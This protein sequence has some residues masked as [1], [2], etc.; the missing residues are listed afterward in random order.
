MLTLTDPLR[1][2]PGDFVLGKSVGM[3]SGGVISADRGRRPTTTTRDVGQLRNWLD[4][5]CDYLS[6]PSAARPGDV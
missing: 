2:P 6:C 5:I 4:G 1:L 3:F